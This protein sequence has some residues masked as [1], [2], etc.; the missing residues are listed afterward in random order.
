[1]SK[2]PLGK[3]ASLHT[4][5]LDGAKSWCLGVQS[6]GAKT[7]GGGEVFVAYLRSVTLLKRSVTETECHGAHVDA[8]QHLE[9]G[10]GTQES[11]VG[12]GS[13]STG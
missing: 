9:E 6:L 4:K 1:M 3:V 8:Q 2:V 12:Q 11:V 7:G 13:G 10:G 5:C